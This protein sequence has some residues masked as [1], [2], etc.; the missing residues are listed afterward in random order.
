MGDVGGVGV[1]G[2]RE[3]VLDE[4]PN[5]RHLVKNFGILQVLDQAQFGIVSGSLL[6]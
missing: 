4:F 2:D 5:R 6:N 3:L 1:V